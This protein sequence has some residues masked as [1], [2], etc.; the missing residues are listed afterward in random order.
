V[1]RGECLGGPAARMACP[2]ARRASGWR[3]G[4]R[5]GALRGQFAAVG[6]G[7]GSVIHGVGFSV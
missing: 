5:G 6:H 7:F 3:G 4:G 1:K 2:L